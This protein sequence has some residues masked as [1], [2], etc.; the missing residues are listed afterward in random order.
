MSGNTATYTFFSW[1][2]RGLAGQIETTDPL[3]A[4][5]SGADRTTV[6]V[7]VH[8]RSGGNTLESV[9]QTIG[10]YGPGDIIGIDRRAIVKSEPQ[11][12]ITNFEPNYLPYI[13]FYDEDFPWRYTPAMPNGERLRPWLALIVLSEDE[14]EHLG[15]TNARLPAIHVKAGAVNGPFPR[16]EQMWAWAHAHLNSGVDLSP[17]GEVPDDGI[18]EML[19]REPNL[20]CSRILC[21]RRLSERT[22]YTAFLIPALEAGRLA[23]LGAASEMIASSPKLKGSWGDVHKW[24]PD[25]WP[26]YFEWSFRT[27]AAGDFESLVRKI[28]P[29]RPDEMD[30]RI[31]RRLVDIQSPGY[32]LRYD[33]GQGERKGTMA[34]EGALR[35]TRMATPSSN[36]AE[37]PASRDFAGDMADLVNLDEDLKE[38][39]VPDKFAVNPFFSDRDGSQ[40]IYDDPIVSPPFYGKHHARQKRVADDGR[41]YNQLNLNPGYRIAAGI[42]TTVIQKN[43]DQYMERAWQQ[44]GDIVTA[45]QRIRRERLSLEL[46]ESLVRKHLKSDKLGRL[47]LTAVTAGVHNKIKSGDRTVFGTIDKNQA[48][49]NAFVH[50]VYTKLTRLRGPLMHRLQSR[51]K[52]M[53]PATTPRNWSNWSLLGARIYPTTTKP[54]FPQIKM[55]MAA[56]PAKV[57]QVFLDHFQRGKAAPSSEKVRQHGININQINTDLLARLEPKKRISARV[58]AVF[59]PAVADKSH[60]GTDAS[61]FKPIMAAPVFGEPMYRELVNLSNDYLIPNLD[62]IPENSFCLFENNEAF[63]E[64]YLVGLNHEM[65]REMLWREYPTDQR[66]T[67]FSQFWDVGDNLETPLAD[68]LPIHQWPAQTS[69]GDRQHSPGNGGSELV[70]AIRAD[71]LQKYPNTIIYMQRAR[72]KS[73]PGGLRQLSDAEDA[74]MFPL[75]HAQ[76]DPDISFFGFNLTADQALGDEKDPGWFFILK[77]RSG[78]VRFGL[79]LDPA[80]GQETWDNLSWADLR[81][82]NETIDLERD[83]PPTVE[84]E[85]I[86]WGKGSG[87]LPG[88]PASGNGSA[89]DMAWI[90]YQKPFMVAVHARELLGME[91]TGTA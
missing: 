4:R 63:I 21:P 60:P 62:L 43:Q 91:I 82:L 59:G 24:Q 5:E 83:V 70:F 11:Q 90:L 30:D 34:M 85:G 37:H 88:D 19:R 29:R 77:E 16:P 26:V 12:G 13:E 58:R 75:F 86:P 84:R 57:P 56:A 36:E 46:S 67:C 52:P 28:T 49:S 15:L 40:S 68:I 44:F 2:R 45:N 42:G 47:Q 20:G 78:E 14:F 53:K 81:Q 74:M 64:S 33:G 8:I 38:R 3:A 87:A 55:M 54:A 35:L 9:A 69:L 27:G 51:P 50:P 66:G 71:L 22:A 73:E 10:L 17:N 18:K 48:V 89:A 76:I 61:D 7:K 31:G 23:G 80:A 25:Q 32:G 41:W 65:A 79:D 1:F 6:D 39:N 72:W